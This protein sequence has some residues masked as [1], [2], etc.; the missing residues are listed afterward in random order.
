M[1][2]AVT[3]TTTTHATAASAEQLRA[4]RPWAALILTGAV[5]GILSGL[6]AI[7]GAIVMVPLLEWRAGMD[8]RRAAATSLVAIIPTALVSSATYL[9]HAD[10]DIVAA[11]LTMSQQ[12]DFHSIIRKVVHI[13]EYA[14]AQ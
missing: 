9:A 14:A 7:G 13:A 8:H 4:H 6:F 3:T 10:V 5:G 1:T 2:T 12:V 11:A